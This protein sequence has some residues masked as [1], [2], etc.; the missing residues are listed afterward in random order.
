MLSGS[1]RCLSSCKRGGAVCI[2]R[3]FLL[4]S[5]LSLSYPLLLGISNS[6]LADSVTPFLSSAPP[7]CTTASKQCMQTAATRAAPKHQ[8]ADRPLSISPLSGCPRGLPTLHCSTHHLCFSA[9]CA[10]SPKMPYRRRSRCIRGETRCSRHSPAPPSCA[11]AA[12]PSLGRH[13]AGV[14]QPVWRS[15]WLLGS[16]QR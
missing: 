3:R 15:I 13:T 12:A 6:S 9:G 4:L 7:D 14:R 8:Q 5:R 1:L 2:F 11:A 16:T 10:T